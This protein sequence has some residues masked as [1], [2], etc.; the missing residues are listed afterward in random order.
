[1]KVLGAAV[2]PF[3]I[4][5]TMAGPAGV[6]QPT[7]TP[8]WAIVDWTTGEVVTGDGLERLREPAPPG[9]L[10]KMATL[11]TAVE[12]GL[13]SA[14]TR[15]PCAGEARVGG[16][17]VRCS[18]PR[19]RHPLRPA[20]A[21]ALSCNVWFATIGARVSRSRLDATLTALGLPPTPRGA[22][23]PLS[24][25][26]VRAAPSPPLSWVEALRRLLEEPGPVSLTPSG[27]MLLLE[28]LRGAALYGSASAF[29]ERGLDALA[30]TGTADQHS[31]GTLGVVIAA[32]PSARPTRAIVL[33]GAGI[34]GRD[35]AELA[36]GRV[37]S[38]AAPA[39]VQ[40][41]PV[42]VPARRQPA[43][44]AVVAAVRVGFAVAGGVEV[45][46]LE[47]EDYVARVLAGEAAPRSPAAALDALAIAARTFALRNRGRHA[48]EGFD[49]CPLT[50]CQV[51]REPYAAVRD[52]AG[53]TR[54]QRL[55]M[56]S[57]ETAEIYYTASCG[58]RTEK[59]SAVWTRAVDPGHLPSR[60]DRACD[61]EPRWAAEIPARD[62]E[63]AL[64]AAGYRGAA[65]R[66]LDVG[67]RSG[68]GRATVITLD[69]FVPS[70]VSGQDFRMIVGRALGWHL[71]KS[72][73]F[74][75]RRT[76][77]G[78][79][80]DGRGFG[81]GIG[82]CVL[83]SVSRAARGADAR[84][85]LDQY[86]PGLTI[87]PRDATSEAPVPTAPSR[88]ERAAR[89]PASRPAFAAPAVTVSL[90]ASAEAEP[91]RYQLPGS[92][93]VTCAPQRATEMKLSAFTSPS[94][95]VNT[96]LAS[97]MPVATGCWLAIT[98]TSH[99]AAGVPFCRSAAYSRICPG[100]A[101]LTRPT[102]DT[103]TMV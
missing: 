54:G 93:A 101:L 91:R 94:A 75:V 2:V 45:R 51:L 19:M 26:G 31:G 65:L 15:V 46:L 4:A 49:L 66:D 24:A 61:G 56:S 43:A 82:L 47:I 36:A 96:P 48:R 67:A 16:E 92:L 68:S 76:S 73:A 53:R 33:L 62:L 22:P 34:A 14:G 8:A 100:A 89:P 57:G 74:E 20:E 11:V 64:K 5:A 32:W 12:S 63:R 81:H 80:F 17:L 7:G 90:P 85:I 25:T 87:S 40:K 99:P 41:P 59:P 13:V 83:G 97:V 71:V 37:A 78:Y 72:T 27:R 42:P 103:I 70:T 6:A 84:T 95:A 23:M 3:V 28:G 55:L 86:F 18:H 79:R 88:G 98:W 30:K 52:A 29:S 38:T 44:N 1:V 10:L 50:H 39:V 69:G 60:A 9:S 35:A 77:G 102:S 58:G 21:I